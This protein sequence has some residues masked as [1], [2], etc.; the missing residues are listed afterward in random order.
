[1]DSTTTRVQKDTAETYH[2]NHPAASYG[3]FCFNSNGDLFLNSDWGFYCYPWR[4]YGNGTF[5]DFL[6]TCSADYLVQKFAI[7]H[8][9]DRKN[10]EWLKGIRLEKVTTLL[11]AFID[12]LNEEYLK[13]I[14]TIVDDGSGKE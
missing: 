6:R 1:M 10:S 7:I 5:K 3:I 4:G 14:E 12:A 13:S 8:N 2:I 9:Q 11:Q